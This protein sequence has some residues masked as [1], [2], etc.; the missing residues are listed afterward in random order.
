MLG[1]FV[2]KAGA[3]FFMRWVVQ[4]HSGVSSSARLEGGGSSI[5][6]IHLDLWLGERKRRFVNSSG[7]SLL[8]RAGRVALTAWEAAQL[9]DRW[10]IGMCHLDA[11]WA[12]FIHRI[13]RRDLT[14]GA[15]V[16]ELFAVDIQLTGWP[17]PPVLC[18]AGRRLA[19]NVCN[20]ARCVFFI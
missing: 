18:L 13:G 8:W 20:A 10:R 14:W 19:F 2:S 7:C 11:D 5:V 17:A 15:G 9:A 3:E 1:A 4:R 12:N 6:E 16:R